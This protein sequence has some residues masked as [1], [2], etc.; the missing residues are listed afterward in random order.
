MTMDPVFESWLERQYAD[1]MALCGASE[2][3]ALLPEAGAQPPRRFVAQFTSPTMVWTGT[4]AARVDGFAVLFQF[5]P[6]YLRSARDAGQILN[7]L[8][9]GNVFHPNVAAPFICIGHV[10]PGTGLCELI[11]R[12]HEI[13]TFNKLT[14]R[15]DDALN[16]DACV[17]ARR[18]MH[19]FPLSTVLLRRGAGEFSIV[20]TTDSEARDGSRGI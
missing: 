5:A 14:P 20:E 2:V 6:D 1:G 9:P 15:E 17:W 4:A 3:L 16:H 18:H 13:L 19:L 11:Y 10:A 8:A 12:V 7:L